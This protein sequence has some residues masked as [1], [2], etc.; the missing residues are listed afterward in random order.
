MSYCVARDVIDRLGETGLLYAAD[1]D[2]DETTGASELTSAM[3]SA[4]ASADAEIDAALAPRASLPIEGRHDWLR[5]RAVDLAAERLASR[6]GG[7][8][9]ASLADAA[10]RT[11]RWLEEI[12]LGRRRVPGLPF[13]DDRLEPIDVGRPRLAN[14]RTRSDE[15]GDARR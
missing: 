9:P 11:R 15:K 12:R 7:A 5:D 13:S 1:D 2:G 3:G 14:P 6:K 4:L 8:I 10:E